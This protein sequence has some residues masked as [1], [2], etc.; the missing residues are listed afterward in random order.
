MKKGLLLLIFLLVLPNVVSQGWIFENEEATLKLDISGKIQLIPTST[1]YK[2]NYVI[3]NLSFV[4]QDGFQEKIIS[5]ETKPIAEVRNGFVVF[6]WDEPTGKELEF[7]IDSEVKSVN[8]VL[9]IKEKVEFPLRLDNLPDNVLIYTKPSETID[10]DDKDII[11]MASEIIK[12]EDDLYR[13]VFKL[14]DWTKKNIKY[15]LSTLT[16]S[17][18]QKA[19]WVLENR[20]GVCDELTNLFIAMNRA[21]GIPA[22]F[23]SGVSYTNALKSG[24]GFGPHGWA[25]VYFPDYGW[26]PFDVTYG[27]FGFVDVGHVKLKEGLDANEA[28]T[29]FQW[30]GR[31]MD[32]KTSALDIKVDIKE[33]KGRVSD[34]I[35]IE[36][37][38]VKNDVGFGSYNLIEANVKNLKDYYVATE[39]VLSRPKEIEIVSE[40]KKSILLGPEEEEKVTWIVKV[41]NNLESGYIY[42]F[43][44]IVYSLRNV[45]SELR[46]DVVEQGKKFSL[47]GI[48]ELIEENKEEKRYS[49]NVELICNPELNEMYEYEEA[50]VKCSIKNIGNIYLER[51][52]VC[53][54]EDCKKVSLGITQEDKV[55]FNFK[56]KESGMQEIV[57]KASN[58]DLSKSY[59]ID[60]TVYDE[61]KL[62]ISELNHPN[63]VKYRDAYEV[64]FLLDKKSKFSPYNISIDIEPLDKKWSLNQ[65]DQKRRFI[66]KMYG[67]ELK[68]GENRFNIAVEYEDKNGK[69]YMVNEEFSINLVNVNIL[70]RVAIFFK[71]ISKSVLGIFK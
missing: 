36:A 42:T 37:E 54:E 61:P 18:S 22:R 39:L 6:R 28:S 57:V 25:E 20:E 32:I 46:F 63:E 43:P 29:K 56:P 16:E 71:G 17:V 23:I 35:D 45:S 60:V 58:K 50:L 19:S 64:S 30:L 66:L 21:L 12:G 9:E 47:E 24:E 62:E 26:I 33:K 70:Q 55:N 11:K 27:E 3:A 48:E 1:R 69:K 10:S 15:D 38:A 53:L 65:I 44:F 68:A 31:D 51:I 5:V 59:V 41:S 34:F 13:V 4:P 14:G 2:A 49:S 52:D 7:S 8:K 67:S 40:D